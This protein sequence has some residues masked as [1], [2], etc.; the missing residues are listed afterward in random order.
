M[1]SNKMMTV[2]AAVCVFAMLAYL[3]VF[4]EADVAGVEAQETPAAGA[5]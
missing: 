1:L 5:Q 2:A 4:A 3:F